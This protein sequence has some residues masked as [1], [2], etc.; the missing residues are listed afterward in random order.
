MDRM[1]STYHW[2]LEPGGVSLDDILKFRKIGQCMDRSSKIR[3][4]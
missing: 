1:A 3:R 2:V 4:P